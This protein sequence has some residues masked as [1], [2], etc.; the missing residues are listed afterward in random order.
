M[1]RQI[2]KTVFTQ[3]SGQTDIQLR[4]S[5]VFFRVCRVCLPKHPADTLR[6]FNLE[7]PIMYG[8]VKTLSRH[9]GTLLEFDLEIPE[10]AKKLPNLPKT[11]LKQETPA[12]PGES[13][14]HSM[15]STLGTST[16]HVLSQISQN[17][18]FRDLMPS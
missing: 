10:N 17:V 1:G 16:C 9:L 8:N 2:Y 14:L 12:L 7:N 4:A 3:P 18:V 15:N 13:V 6:Q 11:E 5:F